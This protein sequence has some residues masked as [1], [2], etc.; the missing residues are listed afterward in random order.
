MKKLLLLSYLCLTSIPLAAQLHELGLATAH[1]APWK[2]LFKENYIERDTFAQL[3]AADPAPLGPSCALYA[4]MSY[5][6]LFALTPAEKQQALSL[7]IAENAP[8]LVERL[9][10]AHALHDAS[11]YYTANVFDFVNHWDARLKYRRQDLT[12]IME[13]LLRY[14]DI[15]QLDECGNTPLHNAIEYSRPEL[16]QFLLDH[17]ADVYVRNKEGKTAIELAYKKEFHGI[18]RDVV[19]DYILRYCPNDFKILKIVLQHITK[20]RTNNTCDTCYNKCAQT[21]LFCPCDHKM[22]CSQECLK[23][24]QYHSC[25]SFEQESYTKALAK[26]KKIEEEERQIKQKIK[27]ERAEYYA[28]LRKHLKAGTAYEDAMDIE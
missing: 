26:L 2:Q 24:D 21:A 1:Y 12:Q 14:R 28:Q 13:L 19:R 18:S 25:I 11:I 9:L 17:G 15:N 23:H 27:R 6:E 22:F 5:D 8:S 10:Q 20:K 4:N 3:Q 16:V 7:A